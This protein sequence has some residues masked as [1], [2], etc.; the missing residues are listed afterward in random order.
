MDIPNEPVYQIMNESLRQVDDK[1][2]KNYY[3]LF[4]E[5]PEGR[6]K[7]EELS[8]V[9]E[10]NYSALVNVFDTACRVICDILYVSQDALATYLDGRFKQLKS[11]TAEL[12]GKINGVNFTEKEAATIQQIM[13]KVFEKT[14]VVE[15]A[16][17]R[18]MEIARLIELERGL[19][20]E[21]TV[22]NRLYWALREITEENPE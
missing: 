13:L 2:E 8:S 6:D 12:R 10:E 3:R 21:H 11:A 22:F 7:R 15:I 14:K 1:V 5:W 17:S 18:H 4:V 20:H 9:E 16:K 19:I